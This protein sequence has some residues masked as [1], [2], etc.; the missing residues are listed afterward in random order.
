MARTRASLYVLN[1]VSPVA[2]CWDDTLT[3]HATYT[4]G[5]G[6]IPLEGF[7]TKGA[8]E[9]VRKRLEREARLTTPIGSYL[10]DLVDLVAG[11]TDPISKAATIAGLPRPIYALGSTAQEP[12]GFFERRARLHRAIIGWWED[13]AGD[14]TPEKNAVL[15]DALFPDYQFYTVTRALFEE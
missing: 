15:W 5:R 7:V 2:S 6:S 4:E 3:V 14:L 11:E 1:R 12:L 8:A 10:F 9:A 13:I